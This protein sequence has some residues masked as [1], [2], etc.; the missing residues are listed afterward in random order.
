M[1]LIVD[2]GADDG[3]FIIVG[4]GNLMA[5][6]IDFIAQLYKKQFEIQFHDFSFVPVG[7][8][9]YAAQVVDDHGKII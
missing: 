3:H 2:F 7:Y 4:T 5:G 1:G 8:V 6:I 9:G